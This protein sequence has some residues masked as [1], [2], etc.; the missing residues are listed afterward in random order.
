MA[1]DHVSELNIDFVKHLKFQRA[2]YIGI[3]IFQIYKIYIFRYI[4]QIYKNM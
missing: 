2:L 3:Y 4:F 1:S